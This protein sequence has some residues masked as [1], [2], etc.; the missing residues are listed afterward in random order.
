VVVRPTFVSRLNSNDVVTLAD[1]AAGYG[2]RLA[3]SQLEVS[4]TDVLD[5]PVRGRHFFE[6]LIPENG[7]LGRP[8]SVGV[9]FALRITHDTTADLRL[10]HQRDHRWRL[11]EAGGRLQGHDARVAESSRS[12]RHP[13]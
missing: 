13:A 12:S 3:I 7:D 1:R 10:S 6:A 9:L 11:G 2:H 5:R 8:D 4:L